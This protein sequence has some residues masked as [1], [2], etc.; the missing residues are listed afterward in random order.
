MNKLRKIRRL[1]DITQEELAERLN[2]T[3][4]YLSMIES[5][6]RKPSKRLQQKIDEVFDLSLKFID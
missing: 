3:Q 5:G 1:S 4:A 6:K 2:V